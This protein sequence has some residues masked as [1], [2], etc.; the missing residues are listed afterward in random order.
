MYEKVISKDAKNAL[1]LLG[2]SGLLKEAYLAGGTA[3]ALQIGHRIS[4]D[5]DFFTS[6][7]FNEKIFI[8]QISRLQIK[9]KLESVSNGTILGYL[10]KTQFSLFY[11]NYPVLEKFNNFF[12]INIATIK[13]IAPMKLSAICDRGTKRDFIDL[14]FIISYYKIIS[15]QEIFN[16]YNKKFKV[17]RQ[18]KIHILKSLIY[19]EDAE[20]EPMPKMLKKIEWNI[21]KK[22]FEKEIKKISEIKL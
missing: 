16:F 5:L 11:Y 22:F 14:Y 3:L 15:M 18:N 2:E 21:V 7:K 8:E 10:G 19:F 4:I 1:V 12:S 9:F 20:K 13:D 6:K 17:F